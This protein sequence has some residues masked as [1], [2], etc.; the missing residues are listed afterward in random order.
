M[1]K[2]KSEEMKKVIGGRLTPSVPCNPI[3]CGGASGPCYITVP[4]FGQIEGYCNEG[5]CIINGII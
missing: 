5:C 2:L 4:P 1:K 3:F